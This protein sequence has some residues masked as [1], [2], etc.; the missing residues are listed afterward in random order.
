MLGGNVVLLYICGMDGVVLCGAWYVLVVVVYCVVCSL[1]ISGNICCV[2]GD[3][4]VKLIGSAVDVCLLDFFTFGKIDEVKVE[5]L[6]SGVDRGT[7]ST[8]GAWL[9]C[10]VLD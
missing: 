9:V 4:N 3:R 6:L 1:D 7:L 5:L 8:V 2:V 10:I